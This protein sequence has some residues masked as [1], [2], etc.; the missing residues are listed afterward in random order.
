LP[1]TRNFVQM[2]GLQF[3]LL[4]APVMLLGLFE[5]FRKQ[6][7]VGLLVV[8]GGVVTLLVALR[9]LTIIGEDGDHF[10][11]VY[12]L[13]AFCFGVGAEGLLT[14]VERRLPARRWVPPLLGI[15]LLALPAYSAARTMP[16]MLAVQAEQP[17]ALLTP[18]LPQ[19]AVIAGDWTSTTPVRYQQLV[20]GIR[21]DLFVFHADPAGIRLLA[22]RAVDQGV[23]FYELRTGASGLELLPI[24]LRNASEITNPAPADEQGMSDEVRWRGYSLSKSSV[25]PGD[26]LGIRLY[27]EALKPASG[28]WTTFIHLVGDDGTPVAQVDRQPLGPEF[29]LSQWRPGLLIADPYELTIPKNVKPGRY[30]IL[31]GWYRGDQRLTWANGQNSQM[32]GEIEVAAP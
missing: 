11:P 24:P 7:R 29:D 3:P 15:A 31:F 8:L 27:W 26:I 16:S 30:R 32:L 1:A 23:A 10:I 14:W 2:L 22:N 13:L 18:D 21:P 12:M 6:W 19:G 9:W 25:R 4:A 5:L 28:E 17:P 20:E